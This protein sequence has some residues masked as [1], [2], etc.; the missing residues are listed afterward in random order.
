MQKRS[1]YLA[2]KYK[3]PFL[4][5]SNLLRRSLCTYIKYIHMHIAPK[6]YYRSSSV[7]IIYC[8]ITFFPFLHN[9]FLWVR[10]MEITHCITI[11]LSI[12]LWIYI[13]YFQCD[14]IVADIVVIVHIVIQNTTTK[15]CVVFWILIWRFQPKSGMVFRNVSFGEIQC[16]LRLGS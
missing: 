14:V 8:A 9:I 1:D 5:S 7:C 11:L 12:G 2:F 3:R 6:W 10:D 13:V 15:Y 4:E 16:I